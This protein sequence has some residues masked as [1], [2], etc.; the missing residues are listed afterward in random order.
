M[1]YGTES[2][3]V[4]NILFPFVKSILDEWKKMSLSES[5]DGLV[6]LLPVLLYE[7]A[8]DKSFRTLLCC[9]RNNRVFGGILFL[10]SNLLLTKTRETTVMLLQQLFWV[11][12]EEDVKWMRKEGGISGVVRRLID[13]NERERTVRWNGLV[14]LAYLFQPTKEKVRRKEIKW[15]GSEDWRKVMW[16]LEEEDAINSIVSALDIRG[17]SSLNARVRNSIGVWLSS[18]EE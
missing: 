9:E 18:K 6:C 17:D 16:T 14:A 1:R 10:S 3:F 7:T 13:K 12:D 2:L 11:G 8:L 4:E 15:K 5:D